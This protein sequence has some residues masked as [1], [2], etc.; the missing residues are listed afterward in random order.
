[1]AVAPPPGA[2]DPSD[3]LPDSHSPCGRDEQL[4]PAIALAGAAG[5]DDAAAAAAATAA[6]EASD[7][8]DAPVGAGSG[9][10]EAKGS[11]FPVDAVV[12]VGD[13]EEVMTGE[14]ASKKASLSIKGKLTT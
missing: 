13:R 11:S 3:L 9:A 2:V 14:V 5:G 10:G 12:V 4:A 8:S 6:A 1:M 7:G